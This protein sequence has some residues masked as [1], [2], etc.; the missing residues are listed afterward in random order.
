MCQAPQRLGRNQSEPI[1]LLIVHRWDHCV[2][3]R[4][5]LGSWKVMV[6]S[7]ATSLVWLKVLEKK[8]D[9]SKFE[10]C[11]LG[12]TCTLLSS[13]GAEIWL[14]NL[15]AKG[16]DPCS[17]WCR[18]DAFDA[19]DTFGSVVLL[20]Q[21]EIPLQRFIHWP[22]PVCG[23]L[24]QLLGKILNRLLLMAGP[25]R[26]DVT[27]RKLLGQV[28]SKLQMTCTPLEWDTAKLP[29]QWNHHASVQSGPARCQ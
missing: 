5:F 16:A 27:G 6:S 26:S 7:L 4:S 8:G 17:L 12:K 22:K 20:F 2:S 1:A 24:M 15:A 18:T 25:K 10:A 3:C 21:A 9:W 23:D 28:S 11:N 14:P 29:L 19:F 13:S